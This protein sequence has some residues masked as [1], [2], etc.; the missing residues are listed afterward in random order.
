[1]KFHQYLFITLASAVLPLSAVNKPP[2]TV[3]SGG[4][5]CEDES[6]SDESWAWSL[7][8]G[9]SEFAT[10]SN[11]LG[12]SRVGAF[13]GSLRGG[14]PRSF[15]EITRF[16]DGGATRNRQ[17]LLI[18]FE[19]KI[20]SSA[21]TDPGILALNSPESKAAVIRAEGYIRQVKTDTNLTDIQK[22]PGGDGFT[23]RQWSN[24]S[25]PTITKTDGFF[26]IPQEAPYYLITFKNPD[27]PADLGRI[28]KTIVETSGIGVRTITERRAE[29]FIA[30]SNPKIPDTYTIT[31]YEGLDTTGTQLREEKL[32]YSNRGKGTDAGRAQPGVRRYWDYNIE[33]EISEATV[34]GTGAL[35][36]LQ[37]ISHT[38]EKYKDFTIYDGRGGSPSSGGA[39]LAPPDRGGQ[40]GAR[41]M[42]S[43]T[44]GYGTPEAKETVYTFIDTPE[45]PYIHGRTESSISPDGSW[46][47]YEYTDSQ[48][49]SIATETIY[50]SWKN[51]PITDRENAQKVVTTIEA[52]KSTATTTIAGQ[53]VAKSETI[54]SE[55]EDGSLLITTRNW[56]G[57]EWAEHL[58][59]RYPRNGNAITSGRVRWEEKPDGT[60]ATYAYT[61]SGSSTI[62]TMREGAGD[63]TGITAGTETIQSRNIEHTV[64]SE[65]TKDIETGLT[66]NGWIKSD[67]DNKGRPQRTDYLDTTYAISQYT[68]CGLGFSRE[69]DGATTTYSR[70]PLKRAYKMISKRSSD[71]PEVITVNS[72]TGL[73]SKTTRTS[74]GLTLLVSES[75]SNLAG[76]TI[77]MKS[78][79]ANGD[80][81]P[82]T[83][84][85]LTTYPAGGG[86]TVAMT[87]PD[88]STS[89]RSSFADGQSASLTGTAQPSVTYNHETHALNGGGTWS[90]QTMAN[91]TEWT[92]TYEDP[93][94]RTF[95][96]EFP[97]GAFS[98]VT[99]H[100]FTGSKGSRGRAASAT[101]P[102]GVSTS[103]SYDLEGDASGTIEQMPANQ[104]RITIIDNDVVND[105]DTGVSA[106]SSS[107]VNGVLVSTSFQQTLGYASKSVSFGLVSQS[108][109]TLPADGAW[110]MRSTAPDGTY[111]IAT[112]TDGLMKSQQSFGADD[113]LIT[114][115]SIT[116]DGFGRILTSTDSRTGESTMGAYLENGAVT[117]V[118][119]PGNRTTAFTYDVMGRTI[120][121]D[122]PDTLDADGNNLS[123]IT[124][125]SYTDR[126]EVAATWGAQTNP[127]FRIYDS[128]GRMSELRT[129]RTLAPDTEPTA[130]TQGFAT[131]TWQYQ[132]QRGFLTA[133]RD[134]E[135]KG[136][137]YT[138]TP[139]GRLETRTW[140]RSSVASPSVTTY[141]YDAG[142]LTS[143]DYSDT[144]PDV[145]QAYDNFGR[146]TETTNTVSKSVFAYDPA[147]LLLDTETVSHDINQDGTPEL[148]KVIDRKFDALRRSTG[149]AVGALPLGGVDQETTYQYDNSGRLS[150]VSGG[151]LNPP[152]QFQYGYEPNSNLLKT[153]TSPAHTVT[154]SYDPT[155]N[156][157][158]NKENK[159]GTTI[160]SNY[161]YDVNAIGQRT[162]I[163]QSGSA[164]ATAR[165]ITW[166]YDPLGQVTKADSTIPG[167]DRAYQYDV[168][169]NRVKSADSLTLPASENYASNSLNQYT[170]IDSLTPSYDDDGNATAY[171]LPAQPSANSTL[172]WDA[173]NRM[174]SSTVGTT[175]TT[176]QYDASSRR[177][178]KTTSGVT[179]LYL[180][181]AW[182]PIA[183][184]LGSAGVSPTLSKTYLWGT[185]LSGSMQGAGGVGGL[186]MVSKISNSQISN[187]FPTY[188][189]NGNV[190]EYL[191]PAGATAAHYE[192]DPFG[193][194]TVATGPNATTFT[195]RFSTKPLESE[196]GLYY[197]GYRYY[198]PV[199]GRWPSRDPIGE[200][201]GINLYAFVRNNGVN[202]SDYLGMKLTKWGG[203]VNVRMGYAGQVDG[204]HAGGETTATPELESQGCQGFRGRNLK[205]SGSLTVNIALANED[206]RAHE[207]VHASKFGAWWNAFIDVV[208]GY[209]TSDCCCEERQKALFAAHA[210]YV[211]EMWVDNLEFD[212]G[213]YN[214]P[215]NT[216]K[217]ASWKTKRD[218]AKEDYKR[219]QEVLQK[220]YDTK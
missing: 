64:L 111:T 158:L 143:T 147:S 66:M 176:Y 220:C 57:A 48:N 167:L 100:P 70:D 77:E 47:F 118:T 72:Y 161:A 32:T 127:V 187:Y 170:A 95:R 142:M 78:P 110:T 99:Y 196:T 156:V 25:I 60:A 136:A 102:D 75:T 177:I 10:N 201:G 193:R 62:V 123:N 20:I 119:D 46:F 175:T 37:K 43:K 162:D 165:D 1:M 41:R 34:N 163:S 74:G 23:V 180:Y 108:S 149:Y 181:D 215:Q 121:T 185:D 137:N 40:T 79:D 15:A 155:R 85:I 166:G 138:Y 16:Y 35:G 104:Q 153:V 173:E 51:V 106:R 194:T 86:K 17:S 144:T 126:G 81:T 29:T 87:Y 30:G 146:V 164:F 88:G 205:F 140:A 152:S 63:R 52:K 199:T 26:V 93:L 197:Y 182:N 105:P 218:T 21:I 129:Y 208:D 125:T 207:M 200:N 6:D 186:L 33:R 68:C 107:T 141:T 96:T 27:H 11:L 203:D 91:G 139:A 82:E 213:E 120:V 67:L 219:A 54:Y 113:T 42:I 124:H 184:Y 44:E 53:E 92:R 133:K 65:T 154:N 169:G 212:Q 214:S 3:C 202:Q 45:N 109:R 157:L 150:L 192:Y 148:S 134:A 135:N 97:D 24:A 98:S 172:T 131:T 103:Y 168:I 174:I 210:Y 216:A 117:S 115:T 90:Q 4:G 189:G 80:A 151:G 114:S 58:S 191:D 217:L 13:E 2:E 204:Q 59:A 178:A 18:S 49:S 9:E 84:T 130:G 198:D 116:H 38:F 206:A 76:D 83:T 12:Y 179:T 19:Q 122:L 8:L 5:G 112:Y 31:T 209:E 28:D 14:N 73:T 195:H 56:D 94:G 171:P 89:I 159:A 145:S 50:S 7:N 61:A 128:Q 101:D 132:A 211:A 190:S 69:R 39:G 36:P 160:V 55:L 188:D 71:G 22:L 183:E